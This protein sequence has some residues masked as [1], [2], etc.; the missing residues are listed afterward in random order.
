MSGDLN[1]PRHVASGI[2]CI[3]QTELNAPR[4]CDLPLLQK[5]WKNSAHIELSYFETLISRPLIQSITGSGNWHPGLAFSSPHFSLSLN[6]EIQPFLTP[7]PPLGSDLLA[8]ATLPLAYVIGFVRTVLVLILLLVYLTLVPGLCLVLV[9]VFYFVLFCL[10]FLMPNSLQSPYCIV[11]S[12]IFSQPLSLALFYCCSVSCGY[13][14]NM[15]GG[16]EGMSIVSGIN[17]DFHR[18][19]PGDVRYKQ[20]PGI[21]A[22]ETS[23]YPIGF[24]GLNCCG[25]PTGIFTSE[26][27]FVHTD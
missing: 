11:L 8:K 7:M 12:Q 10:L 13:Q 16:K 2:T 22:Q 15:Y 3:T 6:V 21:H 18:N 24:L 27:L 17:V 26:V 25:L 5:P 4:T 19:I 23:L 9:S 14:L 1:P 20:T